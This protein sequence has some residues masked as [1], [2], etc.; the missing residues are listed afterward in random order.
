MHQPSEKSRLLPQEGNLLH[1]YLFYLYNFHKRLH[2]CVV[3]AT[4]SYLIHFFHYS[5]IFQSYMTILRYILCCKLFHC[6]NSLLREALIKINWSLK[7]RNY[8]KYGENLSW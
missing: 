6:I 3:I 7:I 8:L 5:Y 4:Q 1:G 2:D